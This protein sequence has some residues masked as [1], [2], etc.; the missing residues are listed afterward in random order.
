MPDTLIL[1]FS[2]LPSFFLIR[3]LPKLTNTGSYI[4]NN[5]YIHRSRMDDMWGKEGKNERNRERETL[6]WPAHQSRRKEKGTSWLTREA[7]SKR[8]V[9]SESVC[10]EKSVS[11]RW[12][13]TSIERGKRMNLCLTLAQ[14]EFPSDFSLLY[15][16][17]SLTLFLSMF[18]SLSLS[19]SQSNTSWPDSLSVSKTNHEQDEVRRRWKTSWSFI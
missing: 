13:L 19:L 2:F 11:Q 14:S 12:S 15:L 6:E 3:L 7:A 10:E 17:L 16:V 4:Y 9:S 8:S 5:Q 1:F 18:L